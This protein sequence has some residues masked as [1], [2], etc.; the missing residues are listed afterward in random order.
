MRV[1]LGGL[2]GALAGCLLAGCSP[3]ASDARHLVVTGSWTMA[4][5]VRDLAEPFQKDHP[6]VFIDVQKTPGD[7]G[8]RDTT[9]GLADLGMLGRPLRPDESGLVALP[10]ARDGL[11]LIVHRDNPV[12]ALADAQVAGIFTQ[13]Y[14]NW[15]EVGGPDRPITLAGQ[16]EGRAAHDVF[17]KH[18]G[19]LTQQVR[20]N[21]TVA[22][23]ELSVDAVASH[24]GAI[25]YASLGQ[26]QLASAGLPIRLLPLGGV[27]AT[28]ENVRAGRYPLVRPLQL[29]SRGAPRGPAKVFVEFARSPAAAKLIEKNGFVPLP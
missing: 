18:F 26:A 4:P 24:P 2:V 5:L 19:L 10:I 17:L 16:A 21:A 22:T 13:L 8:V 6:D 28:L 1:M 3:S 29:L 15:K 7:R 11:A 12:P 14:Q 20:A 9:Q 25:G 27:A 23:S